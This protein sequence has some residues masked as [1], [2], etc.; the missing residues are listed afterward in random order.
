LSGK[1]SRKYPYTKEEAKVK[2]KTKRKTIINLGIFAI[3]SFDFC[4]KLW[5]SVFCNT[6]MD[7]YINVYF[8]VYVCRHYL[9]TGHDSIKVRNTKEGFTSM[10]KIDPI[11]KI[12]GGGLGLDIGGG[13]LN[14]GT[15]RSLFAIGDRI[16]NMNVLGVGIGPTGIVSISFDLNRCLQTGHPNSTSTCREPSD[17]SDHILR[18]RK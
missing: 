13:D 8:Y 12:I 5:T 9:C 7:I 4:H 10:S 14:I 2:Y 17:V 18:Q 11:L 16:S 3:I 6:W 1:Y 15:N